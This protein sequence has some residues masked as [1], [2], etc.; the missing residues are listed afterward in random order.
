MAPA[1]PRE[2]EG[3]VTHTFFFLGRQREGE[4]KRE[5]KATDRTHT[6]A[7]SKEG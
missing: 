3:R 7:E 4:S 2:G 5:R 1:R 6:Q